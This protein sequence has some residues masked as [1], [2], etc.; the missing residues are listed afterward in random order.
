M[1]QN[2]KNYSIPKV[3]VISITMAAIAG[4]INSIMLI[5]FGLPVSQM[6]GIASHL[7]DTV[8]NYNQNDIIVSLS[9][10]VS[11]IFG[12]FLSGIIIGHSQYKQDKSYGIALITGSTALFISTALSFYFS[13]FTLIFSALA[14]GLQNAMV[15]NYKGLQIRTTHVTGIST[16]IGIAFANRVRH[17]TPFD[18]RTW[19][20]FAIF[21]GFLLGGVIGIFAFQLYNYLALLLPAIVNGLLAIMYFQSFKPVGQQ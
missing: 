15:A 5:E 20:L 4:Y 2:T 11:F 21:L 18:W 16:D 7:S 10:L 12:A 8:F 17:K 1:S 13:I 14:C 6:T 9:I 3:F 19:L